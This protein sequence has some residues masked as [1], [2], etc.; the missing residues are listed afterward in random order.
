MITAKQV[1]ELRELSGAGMMDCK[2]VL[3]ETDGDV[4]KALELLRE[5]GISK[6]AKKSSRIAAEGLVDIYI[7]DDNKIGVAL[8]V[9]A[10]TDFVAKNDQFKEYVANVAKIVADKNPKDIEELK[11]L[12]YNDGMTVEEKITDLIATIGENMNLRRFER[13]ATDG[14][15]TGYV[16]GLRENCSFSRTF[17]R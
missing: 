17:K 11:K 14:I 12:Q 16:H 6:A 13:I 2:K 10:E 1:K 9:N 5:R 15:V 3:V 4:Q 7:S 8:E